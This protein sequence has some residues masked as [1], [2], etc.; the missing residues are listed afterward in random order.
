M[1]KN[2]VFIEK[3]ILGILTFILIIY[4]SFGLIFFGGFNISNKIL[5]KDNIESFIKNIDIINILKN[6][7]GNEF[8][9][10]KDELI[11]IGITEE[12]INEFINSDDIKEFSS[13]TVINIFNK[14]A[15][16]TNQNYEITNEELYIMFENNI[17]KIEVNS[18]ISKE[19]ILNKL[20]NKVPS[21][22]SN[23]NNL[24]D[25]I[26]EKLENS[27]M[28]EKYQGYIYK[29]MNILDYIYSGIV[30]F[31]IVFV[32]ISLIILLIFIR[33]SFYKSLKLISISF[34]LPTIIFAVLGNIIYNFIDTNSVLIINILNII[35][36]EL[37]NY[38]I[39]YF[40]IALM[41]VILN[42]IM[43]VRKKYKVKKVLY[44]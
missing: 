5:N 10:I 18:N 25:K 1:N 12:G 21:L 26:F 29:S 4:I 24:I 44:E 7:L 38:S 6:E 27:Q 20:E 15:G 17:D 16:V 30:N 19:Q 39:I 8:N 28:L 35:N 37:I 33:R 9:L 11:N 3:I 2:K 22:T 14:I 43:Y 23:I 41:F 31:I 40:V 42:I 32:I 36:K 13:N 34:M